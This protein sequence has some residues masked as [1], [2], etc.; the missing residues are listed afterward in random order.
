MKMPVRL[1]SYLASASHRLLRRDRRP[2]DPERFDSAECVSLDHGDPLSQTSNESKR[3]D[4]IIVVPM[5]MGFAMSG[6]A[7]QT[8]ESGPYS[9]PNGPNNDG[10][11]WLGLG[12]ALSA[13]A[14]VFGGY[15]AIAGMGNPATLRRAEALMPRAVM[16]MAWLPGDLAALPEIPAPAAA[17]ASSALAASETAALAGPQRTPQKEGTAV[18]A[19]VRER[20]RSASTAPR[21][22]EKL[23]TGDACASKD[24]RG[25]FRK[26]QTKAP[27]ADRFHGG[28]NGP[29]RVQRDF[30]QPLQWHSEVDAA[31]P[32]R[33]TT[34]LHH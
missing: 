26:Y 2:L 21:R 7:N 19:P 22:D 18:A 1:R 12:V 20:V 4:E 34:Y 28:T 14:L 25:C 10:A 9:E 30:D 17:P 5:T 31:P 24:Q 6:G 16:G 11:A 13:F 3:S 32:L 8:Y 29:R 27:S 33:S 23:R 15:V